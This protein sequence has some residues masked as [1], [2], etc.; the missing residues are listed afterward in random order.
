[1]EPDATTL[2][3]AAALILEPDPPRGNTAAE[4]GSVA[5]EG[6]AAPPALAVEASEPVA[7]RDADSVQPVDQDSRAAG[8]PPA[9]ESMEPA[10]AHTGDEAPS[11]EAEQPA[12][13]FD[14]AGGLAHGAGVA[15]DVGAKLVE[16][17]LGFLDGLIGGGDA[18]PKRAAEPKPAMTAKERHAARLQAFR[19][20][21]Q[22]SRAAR[23]EKA[24]S[25][26]ASDALTEDGLRHEQETQEKRHQDRFTGQSQ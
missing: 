13:S 11:V 19:D 24:R 18:K 20:A 26:G 16:G 15:L 22:Q 2:D 21:D 9:A 14:L 4:R 17:V 8:T 12:E 25:L 3:P 6:G 7:S 23:Q 10:P 5:V 1:M